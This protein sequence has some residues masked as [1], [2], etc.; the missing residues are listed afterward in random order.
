MMYF[1]IDNGDLK[2]DA[3]A[4][5]NQLHGTVIVVYQKKKKK[6]K[7]ILTLLLC[8]TQKVNLKEVKIRFIKLF[9]VSGQTGQCRD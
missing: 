1:A 5:K 4:C 7:R 3:A 2:I 8:E 6:R 9:T